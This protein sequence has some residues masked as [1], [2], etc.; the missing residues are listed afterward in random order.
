MKYLYTALFFS[1]LTAACSV[2]D[3]GSLEADIFHIENDEVTL[4]ERLHEMKVEVEITSK[5]YESSEKQKYLA[6]QGR[7]NRPVLQLSAELSAPEVN[8]ETLQATMVEILGN[9][10]RAAVSYNNRGD[11]NYEGAIDV[12]QIIS[13]GNPRV[14]VR[15]G[16]SFSDVNTNAVQIT[17]HRIWAA[18]ATTNPSLVE[19]GEFSAISMFNFNGFNIS[20]EAVNHVSMPGFAANSLNHFEGTIYAT[21]GDNAGLSIFN[22][23]LSNHIGY[24]AID[25]ARWVDRNSDY[26]VVLRAGEL[27]LLNPETLETTH[28]YAFPGAN[29]PEAKNTVE[30]A[31]SLAVIAAGP[32]GT[33]IMDLTNGEIVA[34]IPIPDPAELGLP[35]DVV[36]TNSASVDED[37]IFISNGEAGV[38][39]AE[40]SQNLAEYQSGGDLDVAMLGNL[41]FDDLES[42]N[43]VSYRQQVLAI[44]AGL[45]GVKIVRINP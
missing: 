11:G 12:L 21:S 22:S 45:G 15:S 10:P 40:A 2:N 35:E 18:Q 25:D 44:A 38:Y 8:N 32:E 5:G 41:R 24:S 4:S 16:V 28:T 14:R 20:D 30:L 36:H 23:D 43:H 34:T 3:R 13:G 33:H 17:E 7:P 39:V 29:F 27:L 19:D 31:G 26:L 1:L 42:V 6:R 37:L 9:S